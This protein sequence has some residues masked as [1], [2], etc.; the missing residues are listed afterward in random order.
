MR[1]RESSVHLQ[2]LVHN[3]TNTGGLYRLTAE[4]KPG[5]IQQDLQT[6]LSAFRGEE[7]AHGR[8]LQ[9]W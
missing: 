9:Y 5:D 1:N 7:R 8:S 6:E 3:K 4:A 2:N